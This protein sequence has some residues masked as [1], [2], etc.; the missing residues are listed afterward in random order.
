MLIGKL[1]DKIS[2]TG[3][4]T[5]FIDLTTPSSKESFASWFGAASKQDCRFIPYFFTQLSQA[6]LTSLCS[7]LCSFLSAWTTSASSVVNSCKRVVTMV[8]T[9]VIDRM[10][11]SLS[12]QS[13]E[14]LCKK[15]CVICPQITIFKSDGFCCVE[16][17][18]SE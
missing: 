9:C 4:I 15:T 12:I 18:Y 3:Q 8:L 14:D 16:L 10:K 7:V 5:T 17:P 6:R 11:N 2:A 1:I 13:V